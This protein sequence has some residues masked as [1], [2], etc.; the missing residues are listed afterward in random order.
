ME[1]GIGAIYTILMEPEAR[2]AKAEYNME[3][4]P[5]AMSAMHHWQT[6]GGG[7]SSHRS[8]AQVA[9]PNGALHSQAAE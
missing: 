2:Q 3:V 7:T 1:V 9:W 6:T 4:I 5:G 8:H